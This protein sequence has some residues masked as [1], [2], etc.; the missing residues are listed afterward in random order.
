[1]IESGM[2]RTEQKGVLNR[3][4]DKLQRVTRSKK[5]VVLGEVF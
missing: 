3:R 4:R 2:F 5:N 1:M